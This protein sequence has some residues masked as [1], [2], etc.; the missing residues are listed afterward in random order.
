MVYRVK[1]T[2]EKTQILINAVFPITQ[3]LCPCQ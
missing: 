3:N 1:S 2:V